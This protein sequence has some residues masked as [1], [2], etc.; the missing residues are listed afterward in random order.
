MFFF[1]YW[2]IFH[3][4]SSGCKANCSKISE[5]LCRKQLVNQLDISFILKRAHALI[6]CLIT[7]IHNTQIHL[8][9]SLYVLS[10][11]LN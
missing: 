11:P 1:Q 6:S 5:L 3:E 7:Y 8:K 9:S 2:H 4:F 10:K